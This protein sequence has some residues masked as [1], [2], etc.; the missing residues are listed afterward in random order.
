MPDIPG[1]GQNA[2]IAADGLQ[3]DIPW[4]F[5]L[6]D[7]LAMFEMCRVLDTGAKKYGEENWRKIGVRHHLNHMIAH[8]YAYLAGDRSDDH[9][10]N[11]MCRAMFA[12]GV[13]IDG[14]ERTGS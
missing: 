11:I 9:L 14:G 7:P 5:D 2:P 6:L 1:M 3:S 12:K 13:S 4:R 8:V 10:S